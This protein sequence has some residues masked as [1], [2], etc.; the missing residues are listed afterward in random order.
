MIFFLGEEREGEA[1]LQA[2]AILDPLPHFYLPAAALGRGLYQLDPRFRDHLWLA[3]AML[4]SDRKSWGL[5]EFEE[6]VNNQRLAVSQ[7]TAQLQA[8]AAARLLVEG[9][10]RTGRDL[11]RERYVETMERIFEFDTGV[12]PLLSFG[13]NRRIGALGAH[14]V[15]VDP[16]R[17]GAGEPIVPVRW[18]DVQ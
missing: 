10:R 6:M 16:A 3:F 12:T 4:P 13:K 2:A 7:P 8:Y 14:I 15:T 1:L 18:L 9:L 11:S 17:S 5:R